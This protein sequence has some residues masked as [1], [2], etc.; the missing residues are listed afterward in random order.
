M[1]QKIY[2]R[3]VFTKKEREDSTWHFLF[4]NAG[5]RNMR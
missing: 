1:I 3:P 5:V 2:D 4:L